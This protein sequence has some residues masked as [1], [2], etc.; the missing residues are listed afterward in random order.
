[1][2][3]ISRY[4]KAAPGRDGADE[5]A[6]GAA[7]PAEEYA[8]LNLVLR[9]AELLVSGAPDSAA[10]L[11][12][13]ILQRLAALCLGRQGA[14]ARQGDWLP[15]LD[16]HAPVLSLRL[17]LALRAPNIEAR[18]VH[19]RQC[20]NMLAG[21]TRLIAPHADDIGRSEHNS[22]NEHDGDGKGSVV[23]R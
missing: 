1:M 17:R 13:G 22:E 3:A 2:M 14:S 10:L 7:S 18:I 23:C 16:A 11:L 5:D 19:A 21:A 8:E 12:D 15:L 6:S 20:L 9:R 4:R